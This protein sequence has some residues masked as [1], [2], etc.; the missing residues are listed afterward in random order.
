MIQVE[1]QTE[2]EQES[3]ILNERV[4]MVEANTHTSM[5]RTPYDCLQQSSQ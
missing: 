5:V 3:R 1:F 4:A 2:K